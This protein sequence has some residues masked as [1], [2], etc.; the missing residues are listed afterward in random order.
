MDAN[1]YETGFPFSRE[2]VVKNDAKN[3]LICE[4]AVA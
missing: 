1:A 2:I 3:N 4:K